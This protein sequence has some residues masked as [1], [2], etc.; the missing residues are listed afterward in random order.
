M[1][2]PVTL[3]SHQQSIGKSQVHVTPRWVTDRL[4]PFDLDPCAADPRPWDIAATNYTESDDGLSLEWF[5][6]PWVNPPFD[7][8][9][10]GRWILR[11][12]EHGRGICLTHART[13]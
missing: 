2:A 9:V 12:A 3:G 4:G 8:R 10:V 7:R 1:V 11:L 6:R 13:E 5:G